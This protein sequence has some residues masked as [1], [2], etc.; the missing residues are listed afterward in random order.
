MPR[1]G[2]GVRENEWGHELSLVTDTTFT[3]RQTQGLRRNAPLWRGFTR[4]A[5]GLA[6][7]WDFNHVDRA[8]AHNIRWLNWLQN[9]CVRLGLDYIP[10]VGNFLAIRFAGEDG[11]SADDAQKFLRTKGILSRRITAYGLPN[12]LRIS[13]GLEDDNRTVMETLDEFLSIANVP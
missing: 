10:S 4:L 1:A 11:L 3:L 12:H 7:L 2:L 5:A 13:V 8:R 9:A 6:A